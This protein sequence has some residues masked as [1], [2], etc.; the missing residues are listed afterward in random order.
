[1]QFNRRNLVQFGAAGAGVLVFKSNSILGAAPATPKDQ[2][3]LNLVFP[4]GMD[5]MYFFDSRPLALTKA[6]LV[7]NHATV[8]AP[9]LK[10][11]NG[12]ETYRSTFTEALMPYQSDFTVVNGVHMTASFDGHPQNMNYLFTGSAFGGESFIPHLNRANAP[13][14]MDLIETGGGFVGA[15]ITNADASTPLTTKSASQFAQRLA[16]SPAVGP[17]SL[18]GRHVEGRF[19]QLAK[20]NGGFNNAAKKLL[21]AQTA[22]PGLAGRISGLQLGDVDL[23]ANEEPILTTMALIREVFKAG[24]TTSASWVFGGGQTP[25]NLD[26]HD[27]GSA[28]KMPD[29]AAKIM[30]DVA[31]VFKFLKETP[32]DDTRSLFDVTTIMMASEFGRSRRQMVSDFTKSGNDHNPLNNSILLAG[33]GIAGGQVI[34]QSNFRSVEEIKAGAIGAH[35]TLDDS[36]LKVMGK[37]FNFVNAQVREDHP[38]TYDVNEYLSI[39]SVV[40]TVYTLFGVDQKLH[41]TNVRN[42]AFA[43]IVPGLLT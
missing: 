10:G 29:V 38:D 8:D 31:S 7:V 5:P 6:E 25:P 13:R 11:V 1:M 16:A 12:G 14:A 27:S 37:P 23:T 17:D 28:K 3:F 41:R 2:F 9:L 32:Y 21:V 43:Q 34:G 22:L 18:L 36:G 30:Q 35:K 26:T 19:R 42:G 15:D 4:G 20:G 33:R 40:N 39:N 24:I